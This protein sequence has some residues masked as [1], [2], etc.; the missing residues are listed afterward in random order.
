MRATLPHQ[1]KTRPYV[2]FKVILFEQGKIQDEY[3]RVLKRLALMFIIYD[4]A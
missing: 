1:H 4:T 2:L 3:I